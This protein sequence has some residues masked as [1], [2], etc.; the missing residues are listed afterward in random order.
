MNTPINKGTKEKDLLKYYKKNIT[1]QK[2]Y[3]YSN[4]RLNS[5]QKI[6]NFTCGVEA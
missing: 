4:L 6:V 5:I 3:P 2:R 1:K